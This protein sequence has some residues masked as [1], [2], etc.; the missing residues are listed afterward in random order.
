MALA[1]AGARAISGS[2]AYGREPDGP[3]LPAIGIHAAI[4]SESAPIIQFMDSMGW[5][6]TARRA[7]DYFL[8]KQHDSGFMQ[9]F[10]G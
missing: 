4:G 10:N 8:A 9:N 2:V 1:G 6:D 7:L 5:H 3:L